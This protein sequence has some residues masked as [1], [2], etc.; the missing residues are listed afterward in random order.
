MNFF[1]C[2]KNK[3]SK[4]VEPKSKY[5][6]NFSLR[7]VLC[8]V[9]VLFCCLG[10]WGQTVDKY[11]TKE[12]GVLEIFQN[13]TYEFRKSDSWK[14][15]N[16]DGIEDIP[17]V[18]GGGEK[19]IEITLYA[20]VSLSDTDI[21]TFF[22]KGNAKIDVKSGKVWGIDLERKLTYSNTGK[23]LYISQASNTV[24]KWNEPASWIGGE[25]PDI[26]GD[27]GC[28]IILNADVSLTVEDI[29]EFFSNGYEKITVKSNKNDNID[30][31]KKLTYD[32]KPLYISQASNTVLEWNKTENWIGGEVPDVDG[33]GESYV[34]LNADVS[35][36]DDD[37][38][39][40]FSNGNSKI[41]VKS[42]RNNK[43]LTYSNTGKTLY[44]SQA[45]DNPLDWNSTASWI[46][47]K[48]PNISGTEGVAIFLN[49][50]MYA[51]NTESEATE[52]TVVLSFNERGTEEIHV[53]FNG[54]QLN[55]RNAIKIGSNSTSESSIG[56]AGNLHLHGHGKMYVEVVE[57]GK[58]GDDV[59]KTWYGNFP[60]NKLYIENGM[61]FYV[62]SCVS[63]YHCKAKI[64]NP[65]GTKFYLNA[66]GLNINWYNDVQNK[67]VFMKDP[68]PYGEQTYF[69]IIDKGGN[70]FDSGKT[71][72]F[73]RASGSTD[74]EYEYSVKITGSA[75]WK[76][77]SQVL[78][79]EGS[80]SVSLPGDRNNE[81]KIELELSATEASGPLNTDE[82]IVITFRTPDD[83][84]DMC[85]IRY[86]EGE[87]LWTG[88]SDN[89]LLTK[90]NWSYS[91]SLDDLENLLRDNEAIIGS[92][93]VNYPEITGGVTVSKLTVKNGARITVA[94]GGVLTV[95]DSLIF[96]GNSKI[97]ARAGKVV[98]TGTGTAENPNFKAK[99]PEFSTF[100]T[101]EVASGTS[102]Y[103][104]S[105]LH[106]TTSL[107]N[108]GTFNA[109]KVYFDIN[110][111]TNK[112]SI[113]GSAANISEL[114]C[115]SQKGKTLD[116]NGTISV[117]KIALSG[118]A[119]QDSSRLTVKS[120]NQSGI[121]YLGEAYEDAKFLELSIN[122]YLPTIK[123][124][125]VSNPDA[126]IF[127][128]V[129][130][131]NIYGID[132]TEQRKSFYEKGW[133]L[134]KPLDYTWTGAESSDWF[135]SSNWLELCVPCADSNVTIRVS[136][137]DKYPTL[138]QNPEKL[139]SLIIEEDASIDFAGKDVTATT[140][141]NNGTVRLT[142]KETLP[143]KNKIT[144]NGTVRYYRK[145]TEPYVGTFVW[146]DT[147]KNLVIEDG[148][149]GT[150]AS[151]FSGPFSTSV[152]LEVSESLLFG[153]K[154]P[155]SA[156]VAGGPLF[157]LEGSSIKIS[158]ENNSVSIEATGKHVYNGDLV[159]TEAVS[160][161][162][163]DGT[164][165]FLGTDNSFEKGLT[166]DAPNSEFSNAGTIT[167]GNG[168]LH[169]ISLR[170]ENSGTLSG[171]EI[172]I[173]SPEVI[174]SGAISSSVN[175]VITGNLYVDGAA[176][177]S[178]EEKLS[179]TKDM[180][181]SAI[182]G[183]S[184]TEKDVA[185][186]GKTVVVSGN[187]ALFNGDVALNSDLSVEKDV[188]LLNGE[189]SGEN[190]IYKDKITGIE[191]IFAYELDGR[192]VENKTAS[193]NYDFTPE[194]PI[195][196]I[197]HDK[198]SSTFA[199]ASGKTITVG[200]NF[201]CNGVDLGTNT[202][203]EWY[204][205]IP[206]NDFATSAFAECYNATI[207]NCIVSENTNSEDYA[208]LSTEN[209]TDGNGNKNVAFSKEILTNVRTI[210]DC[211]IEVS[212]VDKTSGNPIKIEN[213]CDEISAWLEYFKTNIR[214]NATEI[215]F[216]SVY[217]DVTEPKK[218]V[219]KIYLK[220]DSSWNTDATG[221]SPGTEDSTDT[222]GVHK[223]V[224]PN[225]AFI[226]ALENSYA[227][228][229]DEHK[230][231]LTA[232]PLYVDTE[233]NA[234]P[235]LIAVSIGQ[236]QHETDSDVQ[237]HYD[238]HN[239]IEWRFSEPMDFGFGKNDEGEFIV[240]NVL[241]TDD[242]GTIT[243]KENGFKI[244]GLGEF[245]SG[246][247]VL[248]SKSAGNEI[249]A[250]YY[251]DEKNDETH[252]GAYS[253]KTRL[254]LSIAG[255]VDEENPVT[256]NG[257]NYKNWIGF[258]DGS[259][260]VIPT[261]TFST[262]SENLNKFKDFKDSRGNNCVISENQTFVL[263]KILLSMT[264]EQ[265]AVT[266][267][268]SWDLDPP[269]VS[270]YSREGFITNSAQELIAVD[271]SYSNKAEGI[272]IHIL[273]NSLYNPTEEK[274]EY[275][276]L[277]WKTG[278]GWKLQGELILPS[279][280]PLDTKGGSRMTGQNQTSGGIRLSSIDVESFSCENLITGEVSTFADFS[281]TTINEAFFGKSGENQFDV[282]YLSLKFENITENQFL[283]H[284]YQLTYSRKDENGNVRGYITDL[285]GN[286]LED[287]VA[288]SPDKNPPDFLLSVGGVGKDKLYIIFSKP[289]D[290][291]T[292]EQGDEGKLR[293][294]VKS[295]SIF[296]KDDVD[297]GLIDFEKGSR[298]RVLTETDKSTGIEISLTRP[299][300]YEEIKTLYIGVN[301]F[302]S[303]AADSDGDKANTDP[304]SG[305]P[306]SFSMLYDKFEN[307]ISATSKH[308]FT[309]FAVNAL[310]VLYAYDGR[311][312]ETAI[313][314]QGVLGGNQWLIT[315]FSE[316]PNPQNRVLADK[317]ITIFATIKDEAENKEN[318][319]IFTM[320]ADISPNKNAT[321]DDFEV[322]TALNPRLWFADSI[323]FY[324]LET[325]NS[326]V[327]ENFVTDNLVLGDGKVVGKIEA[328]ISGERN[329][330][331][332]YVIPNDVN[333]DESLNWDSG[334]EIQ[335]VFKVYDSAGNAIWVDGDVNGEIDE[336]IDSS[337]H[338][339]Y[340]VRL[341]DE[342]D[343]SSIDLWSLNIQD[344][345]QQKGGVTILNNV[346]DSSNDEKTVVEVEV[347]TAGNLTVQVL[348]LDGNVVK[349][350]QRGRV[351]S[352]K[353]YY[354]WDGKNIAGDSVARGMYFIRVV[355]P[356]LDETRKVMVVRN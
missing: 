268:G 85:E 317:D 174:F 37:I 146:N 19:E 15:I 74:I 142:G 320:V 301:I 224:V 255:Y 213:S 150:M 87:L 271:F 70:P 313:A 49:G 285:A 72:S 27:D 3:C 169:V 21:A 222:S 138:T 16:N 31:T 128:M 42:N 20:N 244:A 298:A 38:A 50:D 196:S 134:P 33:E 232:E 237:H 343:L 107:T 11:E 121:I 332:N 228:L 185:L 111:S 282:P 12:P 40:F 14:D 30:G 52:E 191:G 1:Y 333:S 135:T 295:L 344:I 141:T 167:A 60:D 300:T 6:S 9:F 351:D 140:I 180:V 294:I 273:D 190:S 176:D 24:L 278:R 340:A 352:G 242:F 94:E 194:N 153:D 116:I 188:I 133:R 319:D 250:F 113:I 147:Y 212:F 293:R 157:S 104:N 181:I 307:P 62:N 90:S 63:P 179:V 254:R 8:F 29:V 326:S 306:G 155:I 223:D 91:G 277:A 43:K 83:N 119:N 241:A 286:L 99:Y 353:Y 100:G 314:G 173:D 2:H 175:I 152:Q 82:G 249:S 264:D 299:V 13:P 7:K 203:S 296:D 287:F 338:P 109:G 308:I 209:C 115:T 256:F 88:A 68:I 220:T 195:I 110:D 275:E 304:I 101:L 336:S 59:S 77:G 288:N 161:K 151:Q 139:S 219:S 302:Q 93:A 248:G 177:F 73:E 48:C 323:K 231:R 230:N 355:G 36:T 216:S 182:D 339:L 95:D 17:D 137:S 32:G 262:P 97:D 245:Q 35:L 328:E 4:A 105:D 260:S 187:F 78:S 236:E 311:N 69:K 265:K 350:L 132:N 159:F 199:I 102:F 162:S 305:I 310:D 337:D 123:N 25:V 81:A 184:Q 183:D 315:D 58:E 235:A 229:R 217:F 51:E 193:T 214:E 201:Y 210:S 234:P 178:F 22:S 329:Q 334:S 289:I 75:T 342:S 89:N 156:K 284:N 335:F 253:E 120:E 126:E 347:A 61:E 233:D 44:I 18:S 28:Y 290:W 117:G 259:N 164:V 163:T 129:A 197:S 272:Q 207:K 325:N 118:V 321:G 125:N 106:I 122:D 186:G 281:Q 240:E 221:K 127:I 114:I 10:M 356:N 331:F 23:P 131:S 145:G 276:N 330:N 243:N 206:N 251:C 198:Y 160:I 312:E 274:E 225:L 252:Y 154:S 67:I 322:Y 239:F 247:L 98:F 297:T 168:V 327:S 246:K 202:T 309:D 261:G 64:N 211:I 5:I 108:N 76:L 149:S 66:S 292:G 166:L 143:S 57:F 26:D 345:V 92:G 171:S 291:K 79:N 124:G 55:V 86:I 279:P 215:T 71:L 112:A 205:K 84:M 269:K 96:E 45:S 47:G 266:T 192:G 204:L 53:Y 130:D 200:K 158:Y 172:K 34:I 283:N 41:T 238:S 263:N 46:G 227:G 303:G 218:D 144:E 208:W 226:S 189:A 348:T 56:N 318:Q 270:N 354:H 39:K 324:D 257:E 170:F 349:V 341:K 65:E 165:S 346:I 136:T 316:T 280:T 80:Y 267:Y 258:I 148:F 54:N 103:T